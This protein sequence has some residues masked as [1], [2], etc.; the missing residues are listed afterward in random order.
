MELSKVERREV[1]EDI[2]ETEWEISDIK[3]VR[4]FDLKEGRAG[5]EG[6]GETGKGR[7]DRISSMV[8]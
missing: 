1:E 5:V 7:G 6:A 2:K 3:E 8:F 4:G